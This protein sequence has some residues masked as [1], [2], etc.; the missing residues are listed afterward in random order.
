MIHPHTGAKIYKKNDMGKKTGEKL[1]VEHGKHGM[2][3][4]TSVSFVSFVFVKRKPL[5]L[6]ASAF[7][8]YCFRHLKKQE[9]TNKNR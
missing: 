5:C 2:D 3:E 1:S 8:I 9:K 4:K 7:E 6:C